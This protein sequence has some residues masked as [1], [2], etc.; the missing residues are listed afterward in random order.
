MQRPEYLSKYYFDW[1][2]FDIAI[3]GKSAL[4]TKFFITPMNSKEQV[5]RF[6]IG[7]GLDPNEVVGKA[8]LFGIFQESLQFIRRYFL[9]EGN[10]DGLDLNIP[11]ALYMISD[12]T[13]LFLMATEN[14]FQKRIQRLWAEIVLKIM[15]VILHVDK[16]LR[17]NYFSIIQTQIFDRFYK[18]VY[19]DQ[20]NSLF[21]G[22]KGSDEKIALYDFQT[23]SKKSRDSVIIK[24]LNKDESVAEELFDRVGLRFVTHNPFDCLRV[25][26]F[27]M[28]RNIVIPHNIKPS[29]SVN[30]LMDVRQFRKRYWT[31]LKQAIRN[32]YSHEEFAKALE[33]A[34]KECSFEKAI[35]VD[36]NKHRSKQYKAM[37]FT[38]M[39]LIIYKDP[40]LQEF[41]K[42]KHYARDLDQQNVLAKKVLSLDTSLLARDI[43]FFYP[44]EI[45]IMDRESYK[46]N[47][48]GEASH[49]DYK[50]SQMKSAMK[51][52]F[53][54]L[55]KNLNIQADD[56]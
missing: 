29:R 41:N 22:V 48:E 15:H 17:T 11:D 25:I 52:V 53:W 40:F 18:Y 54:A 26:K 2:L 23:K 13:D 19:R 45:Q 34:S 10:P 12:I 42:I 46:I 27:L 9:K 50:K 14:N 21:L 35:V 32:N 37:Q 20:E 31:I 38:S 8:E 49:E 51:R 30:S 43:R 56:L 39:Q 1:E 55:L 44:F 24:L 6:L 5:E 16:D 33:Q 7:Y 28:E 47:T 4:D 36:R 3:N